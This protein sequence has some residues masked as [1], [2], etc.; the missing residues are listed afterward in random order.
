MVVSSAD[1]VSLASHIETDEG[2][3]RSKDQ[4]CNLTRAKTWAPAVSQSISNGRTQEYDHAEHDQ[5]ISK[6]FDVHTLT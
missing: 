2:Y 6:C 4:S 5:Q 3:D 1:L